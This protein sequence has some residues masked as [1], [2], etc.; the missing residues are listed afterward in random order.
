MPGPLIQQQGFTFQP[1]IVPQ[2]ATSN[3][4]TRGLLEAVLPIGGRLISVKPNIIIGGAEVFVDTNTPKTVYRAPGI[5]KNFVAASSQLA[6]RSAVPVPFNVSGGNLKECSIMALVIPTTVTTATV[7]AFGYFN[8]GSTNP[9]FTLG[10][11]ATASNANFQV[12]DTAGTNQSLQSGTSGRWANDVV[13][14]LVGTR[15]ETLNF[16]RLYVGGELLGSTTASAI[17]NVTFDRTSV[18][19][20]RSTADA[21]FWSGSFF[22]G[23]SWSR[24]L[25]QSEVA[26]LNANPWQI[27]EAPPHRLWSNS[28]GGSTISGDGSSSGTSTAAAT[29]AATAAEVGSSSGTSTVS[30]T[31]ASTDNEVGSSTGTSTAAATSAATSAQVGNAVGTSD[32]QAFSVST[33]TGVGS[34]SGTSDA[35]AIGI[36]ASPQGGGKGG[37]DGYYYKKRK[38]APLKERAEEVVEA[39]EQLQALVPPTA[40]VYVEKAER[41]AELAVEKLEALKTIDETYAPLIAQAERAMEIFQ[42]RLKAQAQED[43]EEEIALILAALDE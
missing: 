35:Q 5:G 22:L 28:P 24:A 16:M 8:S 36:D 30:G 33:Q 32:A 4:L 40:S 12:R 9:L 11:G 10:Q 26:A 15:S 2:I 19:A 37:F 6:A 41:K 17:G 31:G 23:A 39:F 13:A 21:Q 1:S 25:S 3:P 7:Q 29:S 20:R 42:N 27:F 14:L 38:K 18:G 43:D 34:A